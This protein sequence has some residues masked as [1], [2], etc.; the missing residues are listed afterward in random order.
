MLAAEELP[1][2]KSTLSGPMAAPSALS[3]RSVSA[4]KSLICFSS[5]SPSSGSWSLT[6]YFSVEPWDLETSRTFLQGVMH[7]LGCKAL[8]RLQFRPPGREA[9]LLLVLSGEQQLSI[10]RHQIILAEGVKNLQHPRNHGQKPC[11]R[12]GSR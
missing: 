8:R 4:S 12:L 9:L 2:G 5:S 3:L 10:Y 1:Q 11:N 6:S 7:L